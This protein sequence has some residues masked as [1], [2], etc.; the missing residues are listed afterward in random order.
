MATGTPRPEWLGTLGRNRR[1]AAY[2]LFILGVLLTIL[3]IWLQV[4]YKGEYAGVTLATILLPLTAFGLGL[5]QLL[6][7]PGRLS[8]TEAGR[9]LVL[10]TGGLIGLNLFLVSVA[11]GIK[12]SETLTGGLETWQGAEG[13][14]VWV[15][16]LLQ[17]GGLALMFV[18]LQLGRSEERASPFLR[19]LVYGYNAVLT[20]LLVLQILGFANVL[21]AAY[22][23]PSYD[24]T[25]TSIYSLSSRSEN[26]LEGLK[27]PMHVYVILPRND[28]LDTFRRTQALMDN[29]HSVNDKI[30]T[31][32]LSPDLDRERVSQ[33]AERYHFTDREGVLLVYGTEPNTESQFVKADTLFTGSQQNFMQQRR[34][35]PQFF[36]G[37]SELI[38]A[39]NFLSEGKQKPIVYFTQGNGEL[40]IDDLSGRELNQGAGLLKQRLE[41]DNITVKGLQFVAI[42]GQKSKKPDIVMATSVPKDASLVVVAGPQQRLPEFGLKALREYMNPTGPDA[43][44]RKGKMIVLQDVVLTPKRDAMVKT[45]LEEFV[46]EYGV[47]IGDN[48]V[49]QV[50]GIVPIPL[51]VIALINRDIAS[52]NPVAA[53][54][55]RGGQ[56]VL[57]DVRT[58]QPS[59]QPRPE[60]RYQ[61][62]SLLLVPA[63]LAIWTE[64]DL[65]ADPVAQ[66]RAVTKM[67]QQAIEAK[68]SQDDLPIAV[69]VTEQAAAPDPHAPPGEGTPRLVVFG[70]SGLASNWAIQEENPNGRY[71]DLFFSIVS[72]L[73]E[74]PSSVGIEAKKQDIYQVDAAGVNFWRM[75]GVPA[76]LMFVSI[77]GLA[78]GVLVVR[79]R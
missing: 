68:L 75:V 36:K 35:E 59:T 16:L 51:Y 41:Q 4:R 30:Q 56:F 14:R 28:P 55:G 54:F 45:G 31:E 52:R 24:W 32:Y 15:F 23:K 18:S 48:R 40:D 43:D 73:R 58:V 33:L 62:D 44:K 72:W 38:N 47:Q 65:R 29:F 21:A 74:R 34:N 46:S 1:Q 2:G 3:P 9:L 61:A 8:E 10:A 26:I 37:E 13:W 67:S 39:V 63:R 6:A 42:E 57:H 78:A 64:T 12:W 27:K 50:S 11:L 76:A 22:F 7:S 49:L 20:G 71:Y 53:A 77:V 66:A 17:L 5:W 69:A 70:D 79:R 19:R 25:T 60:A